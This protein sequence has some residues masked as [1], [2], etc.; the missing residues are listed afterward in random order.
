MLNTENNN[1]RSS[2]QYKVPSPRMFEFK[3]AANDI[4]G[5]LKPRSEGVP[6]RRTFEFNEAT[7][8]WRP[9]APARQEPVTHRQAAQLDISGNDIA[10]FNPQGVLGHRTQDALGKGPSLGGQLPFVM[11]LSAGMQDKQ[12][13]TVYGQQTG[14]KDLERFPLGAS[15]S[16]F[17]GFI[18]AGD[19]NWAK[20]TRSPIVSG[21]TR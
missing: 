10:V 16:L 20:V 2:Q 21:Y 17:T 9:L 15:F 13:V 3:H 14:P 5:R 4:N 18:P 8:N 11:N 7:K 19:G 1:V 12:R 6:A